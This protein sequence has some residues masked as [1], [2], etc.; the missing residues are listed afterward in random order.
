VARRRGKP[1][2]RS[3][4]L[5]RYG[6]IAI[7]GAIAIFV[8]GPQFSEQQISR[9]SQLVNDFPDNNFEESAST[10]VDSGDAI[11]KARLPKHVSERR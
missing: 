3:S 9:E 10:I 1:A 2:Q 11:A 7:I 6:L 8:G 4:R 5:L